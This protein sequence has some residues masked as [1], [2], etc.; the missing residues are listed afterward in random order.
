MRDLPLEKEK[1]NKPGV[2]LFFC[3]GGCCYC[4]DVSV[5]IYIHIQREPETRVYYGL[6]RRSSILSITPKFTIFLFKFTSFVGG[7]GRGGRGLET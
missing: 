3:S 6:L 4:S 5:R 1:E 2:R 7:V